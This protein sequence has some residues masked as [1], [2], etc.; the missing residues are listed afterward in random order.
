MMLERLYFFIYFNP[1]SP[2][3]ERQ[4]KAAF[5]AEET[6]F[7]PRSPRG[8]RQLPADAKCKHIY[9]NPRSPRGER[10]HGPL[11]SPRTN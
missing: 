3:G 11:A 7:N 10:P 4:E 5:A 8:E 1:R 2:R 6:D 9:F